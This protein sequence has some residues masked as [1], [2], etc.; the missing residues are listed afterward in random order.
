MDR[1]TPVMNRIAVVD[2][3]CEK[4]S[5]VDAVMALMPLSERDLMAYIYMDIRYPDIRHI[6]ARSQ[7]CITKSGGKPGNEAN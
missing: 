1:I 3:T 4:A 5:L 2:V 6:R 7:T